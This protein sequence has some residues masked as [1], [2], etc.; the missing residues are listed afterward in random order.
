MARQLNSQELTLISRGL[1]TCK[2]DVKIVNDAAYGCTF[3]FTTFRFSFKVT[4]TH[5]SYIGDESK[6]RW[7]VGTS[8]APGFPMGDTDRLEAY[9][10]CVEQVIFMIK[11]LN[12]VLN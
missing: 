5:E 1:S 3:S 11:F 2:F 9:Q 8:E 7:N 4:A 12:I 6:S 10:E